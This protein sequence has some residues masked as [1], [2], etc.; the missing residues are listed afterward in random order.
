MCGGFVRYRLYP[1][2]DVFLLE[3]FFVV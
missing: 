3:R 1:E 2:L